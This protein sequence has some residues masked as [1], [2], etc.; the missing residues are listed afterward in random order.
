MRSRTTGR[1]TLKATTCPTS[2]RSSASPKEDSVR[3]AALR[4]GQINLIDHIAHIDVERFKQGY[5][6]K[7]NIWDL[8]LG[9]VFVVFNFRQGPFQD[10]RLRT[11]AAR[12]R[13]Q[14]YSSLGLLRPGR[15]A[16]TSPTRVATPGIWK[17]VAA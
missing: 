3:L 7:F 9:G 2:T 4:T 12:H 17:R 11:A 13:P 10:Q 15:D 6:N 14:R 16:L 8:H 5:S 1:P